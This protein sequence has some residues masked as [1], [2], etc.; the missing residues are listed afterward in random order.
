MADAD[1]AE[2]R[3]RIT[4]ASG[5][6]EVVLK[7]RGEA[8][9]A[10]RRRVALAACGAGA[11]LM[12]SC[13]ATSPRNVAARPGA[14]DSGAAAPVTAAS[15]TESGAAAP[16]G[17]L[18]RRIIARRSPAVNDADVPLGAG[19][20]LEVSVFEVP[21]LSQLKVRIPPSGSITLPLLGS[22]R[23]AGVSAPELEG[24]IRARLEE[25][26]MHDPQVTVFVQEHKSQRISVIGAVR[27]GGVFA[28]SGGLR[29]ADALALTGGLTED[30]GHVVYVIRRAEAGEGPPEARQADAAPAGEDTPSDTGIVRG[31]GEVM[32]A[33]DLEGLADGR[34]ELNLVLHAG[35]VVEIPRAGSYYVGGEVHRPGSYVLKTRTTLDQATVA[36][37]GIKS[38]ADFGDV[39]VY[40]T[41]AD[42]QRQVLTY[43]FKDFEKGIS[44]PEVRP[45]DVILVG[46][47]GL[48][49]FLYGVLDFVR[50]GFGA[51]VPIP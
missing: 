43:S 30:A 13:C 16:T 20:L 10:V 50:F 17:E 42:G 31:R 11:A 15:A 27:T 39:R 8:S 29:L 49:A 37:G 47:S 33:I 36:A 45:A 44:P 35:D 7:Q 46:K 9:E 19:D 40:R 12:L 4:L 28:V 51:S 2:T 26:Y 14:P 5:P 38:V 18:N 48:K 41:T 32:T 1:D 21:E 22:I 3:A 23:A 25:K 6:I 34:P 24:T